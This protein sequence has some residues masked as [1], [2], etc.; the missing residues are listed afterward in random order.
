MLWSL[1]QP[2]LLSR[3]LCMDSPIS[4]FGRM[5]LMPIDSEYMKLATLPNANDLIGAV[6]GVFFAGGM[7]GAIVTSE[8][9]DYLGRRISISISCLMA[10][11]GGALQAG[12]VNMGMFIAARL[13]AGLG[14]GKYYAF[15]REVEAEDFWRGFDRSHSSLRQ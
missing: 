13:L 12:S 2:L 1:P 5:M 3:L 8:A 6:S 4:Y 9:T 14:I 11:I 7:V 10:F 15:S